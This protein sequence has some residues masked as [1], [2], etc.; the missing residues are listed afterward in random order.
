MESVNVGMRRLHADAAWFARAHEVRLLHVSTSADLG[1]AA[2]KLCVGQEYH[3]DNHSLFLACEEPALAGSDSWY[4]RSQTLRKQ[5]AAKQEA[6][7]KSGIVLG[8]LGAAQKRT[9]PII[10]LAALLQ[11][12]LQCLV[13]PIRG[14]VIV[15]A[16]TQVEPG[17]PFAD[18]LRQLL[19]SPALT[20]V[21]FIVMER[22][23]SAARV[24][25]DELGPQHALA[26]EW[27]RDEAATLLD[28]RA[29]VGPIPAAPTFT[30]EPPK[31]QPP[32]AGPDVEPPARK[33]ALPPPSDAEL[34][35]SGLNPAFV[36]GGAQLLQKLLLGGALAAKEG[37]H[38]EAIHLQRAA[39]SLCAGL[40]MVKAQLINTIALGAYFMAAQSPQ[41]A[42]ET[43]EQAA[44]EAKAQSM[45]DEQAQATL[46]LGML[47]ALEKR[48][49]QA[50]GR[51]L[52]AGDVAEAAGN[53]ALAIESWRT[54][55][56]LAFGLNAPDAALQPWLRA[57]NVAGALPPRDVKATSAAE[58]ARGVAVIFRGR[59][60]TRDADIFDQQ[61]YRFE[62]GLEPGQPLPQS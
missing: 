1:A 11:E 29:L 46:A 33:D 62:H 54:A 44:N 53:H 40:G 34:T 16:P 42:R 56:Q 45:A 9:P 5:Y 25:V 24:L 48:H 28:L 20:P 59:G 35:A 55:G 61:A 4:S 8:T 36:N 17:A 27:H 26:T 31:W 51:Y 32:G 23:S 41:E 50:L 21:R 39:V 37:R 57:T 18:D 2:L 52:E 12:I 43:Y 38:A 13:E 30:P 6:L 49:Q 3:A 19:Q 47:D 60:Q 22:D 58:C 15:F 10:E 14:L 7:A